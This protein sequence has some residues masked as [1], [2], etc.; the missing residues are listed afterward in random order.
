MAKRLRDHP[1]F[2]RPSPEGTNR[3][4]RVLATLSIPIGGYLLW[5]T[6]PSLSKAM[7]IKFILA[8]GVLGLVVAWLWLSDRKVPPHQD[9]NLEEKNDRL[10]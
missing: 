1:F 2:R 4:N 10:Q 3:T 7:I 9:A 6:Y 5:A 8:L